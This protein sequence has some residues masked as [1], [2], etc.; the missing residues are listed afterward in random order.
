MQ[1]FGTRASI[2]FGSEPDVKEWVNST[3]LNP[4]RIPPERASDADVTD[5]LKRY[6]AHQ[7]AGLSQLATLAG[8]S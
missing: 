7:Q 2:A 1:V 4:A 3:T 6:A 8:M 5:A